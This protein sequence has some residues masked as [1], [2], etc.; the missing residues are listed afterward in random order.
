MN[1]DTSFV[2]RSLNCFDESGL[3]YGL[4][5]SDSSEGLNLF[6]E[7]TAFTVGDQVSELYLKTLAGLKYDKLIRVD[8]KNL[9]SKFDYKEV[10]NEIIKYLTENNQDL[11]LMGR[12]AP[13]GN[14][15][16]TPQYVAEKLNLPLISNVVDIK[17]ND[18]TS[19]IVTTEFNS[20]LFEQIINLPAVLTIGNAVISKLRT[21]TLKDRML[22]GKKEIL[23]KEILNTNQ[24][25]TKLIKL[26][27]KNRQRAGKIMESFDMEDDDLKNILKKDK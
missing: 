13:E 17:L 20:E 18:E 9:K 2:K 10:G 1:I 5:L 14:N 8:D 11:I 12:Q 16:S 7:K 6:I 22:Y 27:Y 23:T 19:V 4:R 26:E 15:F 24:K 25:N 3:E 21:P